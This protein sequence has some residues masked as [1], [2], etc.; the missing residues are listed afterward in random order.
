MSLAEECR[1]LVVINIHKG[2]YC[3]NRL[4]FGV[5]SALPIFQKVKDT[6]LQGIQNAFCYLDDVLITGSSEAAHLNNLEQVLQR[7]YSS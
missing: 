7:W 5:A 1:D 6:I 4:P 3:Y 2:L